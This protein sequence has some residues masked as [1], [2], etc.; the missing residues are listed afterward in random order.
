M[1]GTVNLPFSPR[2]SGTFFPL[3]DQNI[4]LSWLWVLGRPRSNKTRGVILGFFTFCMLL[5]KVLLLL[6][7]YTY[8]GFTEIAKKQTTNLIIRLLEFVGPE[9]ASELVEKMKKFLDPLS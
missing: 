1:Y 6:E 3:T 9:R 7:L 2:H 4:L 5:F 8:R